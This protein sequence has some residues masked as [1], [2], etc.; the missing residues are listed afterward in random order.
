MRK[1]EKLQATDEQLQ[2]IETRRSVLGWSTGDDSEAL[3]EAARVLI[4]GSSNGDLPAKITEE[5]ITREKLADLADDYYWTI[6]KQIRKSDLSRSDIDQLIGDRILIPQGISY[7]S[8]QNF[9]GQKEIY[10]RAFQ[11]YWVALGF[12]LESLGLPRQ[13]STKLDCLYDE[14]L[15]LNNTKQLEKLYPI[16]CQESKLGAFLINN[17]CQ[18]SRAWLMWRLD[19]EICSRLSRNK[20]IVRHPPFN[21]ISTDLDKITNNITEKL[22]RFSMGDYNL[23]ITIDYID[24]LDKVQFK[25]L[26]QALKNWEQVIQGSTNFCILYLID[27]ELKKNNWRKER[28]LDKKPIIIL[29]TLCTLNATDL[30]TTL[31]CIHSSLGKPPQKDL[32]LLAKDFM[33]CNKT[34]KTPLFLEQIYSYFECDLKGETRWFNYP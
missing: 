1:S 4:F 19:R 24:E 32:A 14:I 29:P 2:Q 30:S 16:G 33:N 20:H 6:K 9:R 26:L 31:M 23:I 12:S 5:R 22:N 34:G 3:I 21:L 8:W 28:T 7:R 10:K 15:T 11:A 27:R 17:Q 13:K 25:Q 18:P